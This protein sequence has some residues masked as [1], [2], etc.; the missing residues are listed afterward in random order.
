[1]T[2]ENRMWE[3]VK[4]QY[5]SEVEKAL[6]SVKHPSIK[7]ILADVR[8]HLDRRH[9]ELE[10]HQCNWE[11]FQTILTEMGP[12][13]D[14]AELLDGQTQPRGQSNLPRYLI[15]LATAAILIV[16]A[17]ILLPKLIFN[18][19][20]PVT[21]EQFLRGFSEKVDKFK[22]DAATLNDV[23]KT[24]GEPVKYASGAQVLNRKNLPRRYVV[25]YPSGFS[26]YMA[27]NKVVELRHEGPK[28]GYVWHDKLR[29]GSSLEQ[30]IETLGEPSWTVIGAKNLFLD[31]VLYKDIEGRKGHCYYSRA[32][33]DVRLWFADYKIA[34]IYM[35]RSDYNGG[36]VPQ[37]K[38]HPETN[39]IIPK[40]GIGEYTLGM[41]KDDVL[42]HLG[43]PK[44][45]FYRD[46]KYTLENL[47]NEYFMVYDDISFGVIN[48]SVEGIS[49]LSPLYK[50][51]NGLG[52]GDS[53]QK[54]K[55]AFGN[56]FV[57]KETPGKDFLTY[58]DEGIQF[59]IHKD[60]RTVMEIS[61]T[62][63]N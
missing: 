5:L 19:P 52:V 31:G 63:G 61:V 33:Q 56:N 41:S 6:S 53:D 2:D 43:K 15:G 55:Q 42:K 20:Q 17:T 32:D 60:N 14:Y 47:P 21:S 58:E 46:E 13:S 28:T 24:F 36:I 16:A 11:T 22:I 37:Q 9:A 1:M 4:A 30:A 51:A 62:H 40:V 34:S 18:E 23:T 7:G 39:T 8:S 50:F 45:V 12:A 10:P 3:T 59:E 57:L 44:V 25:V 27:D 54:I 48:D 49:A 26:V 38:E 35:T 29:V